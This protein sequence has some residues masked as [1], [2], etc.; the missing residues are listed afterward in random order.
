MVGWSRPEWEDAT[1]ENGE[2][3]K[4]RHQKRLGRIFAVMIVGIGINVALGVWVILS[5]L[6]SYPTFSS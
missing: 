1:G 3:G 5:M 6:F 4:L 2:E